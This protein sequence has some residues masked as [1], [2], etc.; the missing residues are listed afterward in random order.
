[1]NTPLNELLQ[2]NH[3]V[4][5]KLIQTYLN[6][7]DKVSENTSR[8]LHHILN[9]HQIWNYRIIEKEIEI[10][11]WSSLPANQLENINNSNYKDSL[12]I[13]TIKELTSEITY[14]NSLGKTYKNSIHDILFH[15]IN[16]STYHRGQIATSFK[17]DGIEPVAT[18][19]IFYK[20]QDS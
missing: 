13:I 8:L 6:N 14:T 2:Y 16:H 12:D 1:M 7:L 18:D 9:A 20:R 19:Y 10:N 15:V 4:N 5:Q 3:H 11:A 17:Q